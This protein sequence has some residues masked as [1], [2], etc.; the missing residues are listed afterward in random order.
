[1]LLIRLPDVLQ[2]H[3]EQQTNFGITCLGTV[4]PEVSHNI[5][6]PTYVA[7]HSLLDLLNPL[8]VWHGVSDE[9]G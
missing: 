5:L 2:G 7:P 3:G 4:A 9:A 1:M 6:N 8:A